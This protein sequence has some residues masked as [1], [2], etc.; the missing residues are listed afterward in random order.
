M[1]IIHSVRTFLSI[2]NDDDS[3]LP[4]DVINVTDLRCK[5]RGAK[6]KAVEDHLGVFPDG[7][8]VPLT[9]RQKLFFGTSLGKLTYKIRKSR[10]EAEKIAE[11]VGSFPPWESDLKDTRLIRH[12]VL[13]CLSPF[14]RYALENNYTDYENFKNTKSSWIIYLSAWIF[15]TLTICFFMY[16]IFVWGLY[17]G[18]DTLSAWGAVYGTSAVQ[19]ILLVSVTKVI[20]VNYLPAQA[21]QAQLLRIRGVLADVSLNYINRHDDNLLTADDK[22]GVGERDDDTICVVQHMSAAC[23]AAR[24]KV[25]KTLPAAWLL[26][27]VRKRISIIKI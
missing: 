15:V 17:E 21:M 12:F 16:W 24:S 5:E 10:L 19:D 7:S 2:E 13:E 20:L 22:E 26:R 18:E 23:R 3:R 6:V 8:L 25:L 4:W 1:M 27:Q 9:A 14:K 11:V